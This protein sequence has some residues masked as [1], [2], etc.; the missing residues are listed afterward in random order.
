VSI[1][2]DPFVVMVPADAGTDIT[3][4]QEEPT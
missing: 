2:A 3:P 1:R 4:N